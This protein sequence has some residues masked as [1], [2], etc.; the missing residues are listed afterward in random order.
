MPEP[1]THLVIATAGAREAQAVLESAPDP[2]APHSAVHTGAGVAV[3]R[4][5]GIVGKVL[6]LPQTHSSQQGHLV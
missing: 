6:T 2:R 5:V 3:I 1:Y 4:P